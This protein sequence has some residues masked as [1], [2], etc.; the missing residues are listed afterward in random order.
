MPV[1]LRVHAE[2]AWRRRHRS[3]DAPSARRMGSVVDGD[4]N[5]WVRWCR[6]HRDVAGTDV[7][8]RHP[9]MPDRGDG[10]IINSSSLAGSLSG[11]ASVIYRATNGH[12]GAA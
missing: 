7:A 10:S 9:R 12:H 11:Y 5:P 8:I 1:T 2:G 4:L 3:G 6:Q